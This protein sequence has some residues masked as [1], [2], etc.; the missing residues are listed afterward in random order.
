M[1]HFPV[2]LVEGDHVWEDC[3]VKNKLH[4]FRLSTLHRI[5]RNNWEKVRL[6]SQ[7]IRPQCKDS[8]PGRGKIFTFNKNVGESPRSGIQAA[9]GKGA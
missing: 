8:L 2:A 5:P 1:D 9:G 7:V 4:I 3:A 6:V